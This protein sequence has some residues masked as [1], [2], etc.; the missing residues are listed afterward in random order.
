MTEFREKLIELYSWR[1]AAALVKRHPNDITVFIGH[2][3]SG[4]YDVLWLINRKKK[5]TGFGEIR[6]NRAGTI[7]IPSRFDQARGRLDEPISWESYI[8]GD[9]RSF[10][11]NIEIY[12]GLPIVRRSPRSTSRVLA[13]MAMH[14]LLAENFVASATKSG[15][16]YTL[17]NG[18]FDTSGEG[19]GVNPDLRDIGFAEELFR[20]L[21]SDL[22]DEPSYRFWILY[23]YDSDKGRVAEAALEEST[24]TLLILKAEPKKL[25]LMHLYDFFGRDLD[26]FYRALDEEFASP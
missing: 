25:N 6:L 13:Y 18:Y 22:F 1:I 9:H 16:K 15:P 10:V 11:R 23:S 17:R 2:P 12:A 7:Q 24:G 26:L 21:E 4:Q 8:A 20:P 5:K 19:G 3:C 14:H